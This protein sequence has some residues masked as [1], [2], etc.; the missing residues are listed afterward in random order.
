MKRSLLFALVASL[1]LLSCKKECNCGRVQLSTN[2]WMI[3][4]SIVQVTRPAVFDSSDMVMSFSS[5]DSNA[6]GPL[7]LFKF[8]D[9]PSPGRYKV[10][11]NPANY[12]EVCITAY[13][14][15][16]VYMP[17][18]GDYFLAVTS[19]DNKRGIVANDV[20]MKSVNNMLYN[21]SAFLSVNLKEL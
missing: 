19:V 8:R 7:L 14:G 15:I 9:L 16:G 5:M 2:T 18:E 11:R 3:G 20:G 13:Y 12:N 1:F 10:V 21:G 17:E 6:V 4:D